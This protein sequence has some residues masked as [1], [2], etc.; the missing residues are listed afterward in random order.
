MDY[1]DPNRSQTPLE[2]TPL[3]AG[4]TNHSQEKKYGS[5]EEAF[6]VALSRVPVGP[7]HLLLIG[8]CGWALAS[9]SVEVQCIS[10]VTPQLDSSNP[11]PHSNQVIARFSHEK[12]RERE[13]FSP[14]DGKICAAAGQVPGGSVRRHHFPRDDGGRVS[15]GQSVRPYWSPLLSHYFPHLQWSVWIGISLL[16]QLWPLPFLP[17][18]QW[19]WVRH[20]K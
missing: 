8:L 19:R 16:S 6:D 13:I 15:V 5:A 7:F 9:D 1:R 11:A 3:L 17:I 2:E 12:E 10:F 14:D 18:P 20:K 4:T